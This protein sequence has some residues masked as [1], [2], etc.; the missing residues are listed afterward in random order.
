MI[1][2]VKLLIDFTLGSKLGRLLAMVI[3]TL[4]SI[5]LIF[6]FGKSAEKKNQKIKNLEKYKETMDAIQ[7]VD[8]NTERDAALERLRKNGHLRD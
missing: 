3:G 2:L 1:R 6:Q 7:D 5:L 8:I 4:G